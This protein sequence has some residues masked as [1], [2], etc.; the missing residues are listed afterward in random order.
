MGRDVTVFEARDVVGGV[1]MTGIPE[2]RLPREAL[3]RDIDYI[4]STGVKIITD[5]RIESLQ[6]LRDQ[7]FDAIFLA[8]GAHKSRKLGV[9]GE[10]LAGVHDALTFLRR[11]K[12]GEL[13]TLTGRVL[14]VGGGNAALDA[15]R[16]ALRLGAASVTLLY[17]RT[18]DEMPAIREDIEEAQIEGID[19]RFL[20]SPVAIEGDSSVSALRCQEMELGEVD[21]SGRRRP[22]PK[23][24]S[25]VAFEAEHVIVAVGQGPEL[26]FAADDD[27]LVVHRG[28]VEVDPVSLRS[29]ASD[30]FA[31]GDVVT[32]PATIVQAVGAGQRAA[33]AIDV[34]LGGKGELPPDHGWASPSKP[35]EEAASVPRH[36]IRAVPAQRRKGNFREVLKGYSLQAACAEARRCLRCDME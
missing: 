36:P 28:W 23:P 32:G 16:T 29:G 18:R 27:K 17:R 26:G 30:V 20:F 19:M 9:P 10:D 25:E 5:K 3:E 8:V 15:A 14:V 22:V 12:S 7:G 6:E 24:D 11:V 33:Q 31:G 21:A 4:R 35:D 13:N 2:Y 1:L 34:F